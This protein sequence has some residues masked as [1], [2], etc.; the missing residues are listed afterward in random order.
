MEDHIM[1]AGLFSQLTGSRTVRKTALRA[2]VAAARILDT[3]LLWQARGRQRRA[4]A[5]FD[6]HLLRD[7]GRSREEAAREC[8]KPVWRA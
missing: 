3:L 6:D 2:E 1:V 5:R 8:A 4:L 7:I